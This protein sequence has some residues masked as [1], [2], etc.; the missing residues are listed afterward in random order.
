MSDGVALWHDGQ[1]VALKWHR[2]RRVAGDPAFARA[3]IAEGLALGA[4][5]EID[6]NP[7][8]DGGFAVLHDATLDRETSGTGPVAALT[9][10]ALAALWRRAEDGGLRPE[11]VATLDALVPALAG[12]APGAL[13]QLDLKVG[14]A[15]LT[16][17]HVAGFARAMGPV[18]G[19]V[20]VSGEDPRALRAL[21]GASGVAI[22]YDPCSAA[23]LAALRADRDGPGFAARALAAMPEARMIYLAAD[24]ILAV[25][26]ETGFDLIAAMHA[27]GKPVDAYTL[28]GAGPG[29]VARA[30]RL[31]ALGADQITCDAPA[32]LAQALQA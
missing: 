29:D 27:A 26:D 24:L 8:A 19:H 31:V 25:L 9:G 2:A 11:P 30:R 14:A 21:A 23:A 6:L 3:R 28:P 20:I 15:A 7:L 17:A 5:V 13:L 12:A 32:N 16:P 10:A 1:R 22:G 18:A 4:S